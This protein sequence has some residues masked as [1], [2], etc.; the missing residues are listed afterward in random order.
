MT[1]TENRLTLDLDDHGTFET[2]TFYLDRAIEQYL[3]S[4]ARAL[5]CHV[6]EAT[7]LDYSDV[8]DVS[9]FLFIIA[10]FAYNVQR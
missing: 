3:P 8:H 5:R 6:Q 10:S 2:D 4:S 9:T 7:G 1:N